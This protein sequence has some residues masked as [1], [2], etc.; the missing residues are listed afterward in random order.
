MLCALPVYGR[1]HET[2]LGSEV[3]FLTDS[4][5]AGRGFGTSGAQA[6]SFYLL[7]QFRNA[8]LRTSV[9]SFTYG[10]KAGHNVI[11]VTPGWFD[12]YVVV[13]AYFDGL[14]EFGDGYYQGADANASGVAALLSLSRDFSSLCTGRVGLIFVGFDGH[15]ASLSG[16]KEFLS[17]F[18]GEYNIELMVNLDILGS[19]LV[20]VRKDRPDYM[21]VLGGSDHR[22]ALDTANRETGL[23][24]SYDYYGS[25][26]FTD[27]FYRKIS[28]QRWFLEA[29]IPSMMFTSGITMNTNKK[30]DTPSTL[31]FDTLAKRVSV[32]GRWLHTLL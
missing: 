22:L 6:A 30:S 10:G 5:C 27:L 3:S 15:N 7:R 26:N 12:Q 4:L 23:D 16:A 25:D 20:P 13:G 32:I 19:T 9:Q 29:G 11:G 18:S 28:D 31:D 1:S 14:G 8:G 24:L 21:I 2:D 17:R